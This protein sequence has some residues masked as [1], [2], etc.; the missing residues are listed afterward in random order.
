MTITTRFEID[1]REARL[2]TGQQ[3]LSDTRA[4]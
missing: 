3:R 2:A 1:E 4:I